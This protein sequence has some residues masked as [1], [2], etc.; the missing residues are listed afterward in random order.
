MST[1]GYGGRW[2][3][4]IIGSPQIIGH[5]FNE[6]RPDFGANKRHEGVDIRAK[7]GDIVVAVM[8]GKVTRVHRWNG[9]KVGMHNY[10]HH[11]AVVHDDGTTTFYCHLRDFPTLRVN[12]LV[13]QGQQL[14]VAGN[15]GNSTAAHLHLM[16]THPVLGLI[17]YVFP[18]VMDPRPKL[19][20][21]SR[22]EP[23]S[24]L[25][26]QDVINTLFKRT[27]P[28]L[29]LKGDE[30][31]RLLGWQYIYSDRRASFDEGRID[32]ERKPDG[33]SWP[34]WV[35]VVA[36]LREEIIRQEPDE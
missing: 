6:P 19:D 8:A 36:S 35:E 4:P 30:L 9:S 22:I 7:E 31:V 13:I 5:Q 16:W 29:G 20:E 15:T 1:S 2:V 21:A 34:Q 24:V 17:G 25:S 32:A 18:R 14:G 23:Q 12:D 11:I 26:H 28:V 3:W 33:V 27:A 10:G